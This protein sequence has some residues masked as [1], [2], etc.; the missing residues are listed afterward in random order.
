MSKSK[1]YYD[2]D[3]LSFKEIELSAS[4]RLRRY[5]VFFIAAILFGGFSFILVGNFVESPHEKYL[6][7]ELE[8][9]QLNYDNLNL[10][11]GQAEV[12]L[13]SLQERD[14]KLYRVYFEAAPI[15]EEQR[16]SGFGGVNRYRKLE[17]F[18]NSALIVSS[19]KK[20]DMLSKRIYTQSKSLDDIVVLA[21][22]KKA[23]LSHI[24]AIQP[25]TNKDL[26]K[27]ASGYGYRWHP[28]LKYR[29]FHAGMDFSAKTGTPIFATGDGVVKKAVKAG[30]FGKHVVIDHGFGYKTL[31]GHMHNYKV[32]KGQKVKRGE[33]IGAVGSTG[34]S[35]G[36]HL[37]Y[38]VHKNGKKVNPVNYYHN[39][40]T[41]AEYNILLRMS[42]EE[43]QTM[44]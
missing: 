39:D 28:I 27:M 8:N 33:I 40:L 6:E 42:Q 37:H 30:A 21:E 41:P 29:K 18:D 7:R 5:G 4:K 10:K 25:V 32:K 16:N 43:N 17:G 1:Y 12:V 38:E 13:H 23:L 44:D 26:K 2:K 31:Y 22:N 19:S 24:P 9:L 11:I 14:D 15:P 36:P 20:L 3:T 34:M 35:T